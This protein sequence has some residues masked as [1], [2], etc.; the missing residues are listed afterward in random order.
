ME[1]SKVPTQHCQNPQSRM[2][3]EDNYSISHAPLFI[4]SKCPDQHGTIMENTAPTCNLGLYSS[5]PTTTRYQVVM[6]H[7]HQDQRHPFRSH[8]IIES[9]PIILEQEPLRIP[10]QTRHKYYR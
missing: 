1:K 6:L 5:R 9:T 8:V 2:G 10:C 3:S 7:L 4:P